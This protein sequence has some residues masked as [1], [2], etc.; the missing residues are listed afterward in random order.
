M[1]LTRYGIVDVVSHYDSGWCGRGG[2]GGGS[3][4]A[5]WRPVQ[6]IAQPVYEACLGLIQL[7]TVTT[8]AVTFAVTFAV[9]SVEGADGGAIRSRVDKAASGGT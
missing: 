5:G 6:R 4:G 9:T 2:G 7:T 8:I 1:G 3:G